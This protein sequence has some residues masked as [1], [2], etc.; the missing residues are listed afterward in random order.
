MATLVA[1]VQ[2]WASRGPRGAG[3]AGC[4][5][6]GRASSPQR[7][8]AAD[9]AAAAAA[10]AADGGDGHGSGT[11]RTSIVMFVWLHVAQSRVGLTHSRYTPSAGKTNGAVHERSRS[12]GPAVRA[13]ASQPQ[14]ATHCVTSPGIPGANVTCTVRLTPH[15]TSLRGS[16]PCRDPRHNVQRRRQHRRARA[17]LELDDRAESVGGGRLLERISSQD[18]A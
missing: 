12:P 13:H 14:P 17:A 18:G 6:R 4:R 9:T 2:R 3:R 15:A 7:E 11:R 8:A 10:A 16:A 1:C 5:C